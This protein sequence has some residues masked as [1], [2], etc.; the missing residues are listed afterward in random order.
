MEK[1]ANE[2][3]IADSSGIISLVTDTDRNHSTALSAAQQLI[4]DDRTIILPT[5]VFTETINVL[6]RRSSRETALKTAKQLLHTTNQFLL[7]DT[8]SYLKNALKKFTAS[9]G[10][11]SFTDC[12]VMAVADDYNTPDIFG[13]DRQ[14]QT[15]GYHRLEPASEN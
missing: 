8:A 3:I 6:G 7:I 4:N 1:T 15:A 11:V 9:P 14:F 13:F 2:A 5:D 10:A 12:I